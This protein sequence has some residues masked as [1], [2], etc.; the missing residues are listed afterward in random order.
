MVHPE[1]PLRVRISTWHRCSS[2][3]SVV[4]NTV[5]GVTCSICRRSS[6]LIIQG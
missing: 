6:S 5:P 2:P 4:T 1:D 3:V